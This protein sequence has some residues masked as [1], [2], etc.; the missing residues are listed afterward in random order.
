MTSTSLGIMELPPCR[1]GTPT[2]LQNKRD[3]GIS[4]QTVEPSGTMVRMKV[5]NLERSEGEGTLV[6]MRQR[7]PYA[8]WKDLTRRELWELSMKPESCGPSGRRL[9]KVDA[10]TV[11]TMEQREGPLE[12]L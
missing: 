5:S 11:T 8:R 9:T 12:V 1:K 10:S 2:S 4:Y 7:P 6:V 3:E